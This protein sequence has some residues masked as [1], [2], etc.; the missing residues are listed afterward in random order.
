MARAR[1]HLEGG[2]FCL[3]YADGVADIDLRRLIGFHR[4][5]GARPR[6]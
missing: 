1:E 4:A 3:T 5:H 6:R 2:T